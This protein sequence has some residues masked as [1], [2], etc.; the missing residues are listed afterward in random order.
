[1]LRSDMPYSVGRFFAFCVA[2][3]VIVESA[4]VESK[5]K[6]LGFLIYQFKSKLSPTSMILTMES[7]NNKVSSL[8]VSMKNVQENIE[9]QNY[10]LMHT[11]DD[12][13]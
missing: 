5:A 7:K 4:A 8:T 11:T 1:M 2:L 10:F 13:Q 3:L 6:S 12:T 9:M